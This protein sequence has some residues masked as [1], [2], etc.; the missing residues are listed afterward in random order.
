MGRRY[1][2]SDAEEP[3]TKGARR[4]VVLPP[5]MK[6]QKDLVRDVL[7]VGRGNAEPPE[8]AAEII[9]L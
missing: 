1:P 8:G 6:N 5:A 3:R 2:E 7:D 9:E 4:V